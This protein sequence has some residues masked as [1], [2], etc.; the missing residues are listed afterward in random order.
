MQ[1]VERWVC[2]DTSGEGWIPR[3]RKRDEQMEGDRAITDASEPR[4]RRMTERGRKQKNECKP[5]RFTTKGVLE[6]L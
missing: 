2:E 3:V 5:Q 1:T 6:R 4:E